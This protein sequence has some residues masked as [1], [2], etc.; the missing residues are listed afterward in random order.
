MTKK[1]LLHLSSNFC[2]EV[3]FLLLD[4]FA[5]FESDDLRQLQILVNGFQILSNRLLAVFCSDISLIEQA[6][7]LQLLGD[8]TL[9]Q[10]LEDLVIRDLS[11]CVNSQTSQLSLRFIRKEVRQIVEVEASVSSLL[12]QVITWLTRQSRR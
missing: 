6:D 4:A 10:T 8:T 7:L 11:L 2:S 3:F 1:L 9:N 12:N 5:D